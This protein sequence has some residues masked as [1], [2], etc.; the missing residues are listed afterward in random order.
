[1]PDPIQKHCQSITVPTP[2]RGLNQESPHETVAGN[3][4]KTSL[5]MT[6]Y[7]TLNC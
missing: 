7:E 1:M 5:F 4:M 6:K 2:S 3:V